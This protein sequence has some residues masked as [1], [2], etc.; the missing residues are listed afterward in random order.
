MKHYI[1]MV[2]YIAI[3][4]VLIP[5]TTAF[6]TSREPKIARKGGFAWKM[7]ENR[8]DLKKIQKRKK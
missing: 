1:L 4:I 6:C 3:K 8:K 7:G 5:F 2:H